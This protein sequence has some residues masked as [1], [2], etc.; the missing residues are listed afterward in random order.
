MVD[1]RSSSEREQDDQD[2]R[3]I[4][5][6]YRQAFETARAEIGELKSRMSDME[7]RNDELQERL[8]NL[9]ET[10][11][12]NIRA[13]R[14]QVESGIAKLSE[15]NKQMHGLIQ[16]AQTEDLKLVEQMDRNHRERLESIVRLVDQKGFSSG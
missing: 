1:F 5:Q 10:Q 13:V 11:A 8:S 6:D 7:T 15:D 3:R 9:V 12:E 14:T 4:E 16:N 2:T